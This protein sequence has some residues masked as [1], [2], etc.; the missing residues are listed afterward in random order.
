MAT[1]NATYKESPRNDNNPF[2]GAA[3]IRDLKTNIESVVGNEHKFDLTPEGL[4]TQGQHK[5]GTSY[6]NLDDDPDALNRTG[7]GR[8]VGTTA[9]AVEDDSVTMQV[10]GETTYQ[11]IK[12][13]NQ[14]SLDTDETI[15]GVKN[16]TSPITMS[17][18]QGTSSDS[19]AT[20]AYVTAETETTSIEPTVNNFGVTINT[21]VKDM[22]NNPI[23]TY[24][25]RT[26]TNNLEEALGQIKVE[27]DELRTIVKA[28]AENNL[29]G[30]NLKTDSNVSFNTVTATKVIGAVWG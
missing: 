2:F 15:T 12:G 27:L 28:L 8:L 5:A 7:R 24:I 26:D 13:Y 17:G 19:L 14:V 22:N 23:G 29:F 1:W 11:N 6:I 25:A 18:A 4:A 3:E 20:L 9:A 21:A 16:F 10:Q 30:Q